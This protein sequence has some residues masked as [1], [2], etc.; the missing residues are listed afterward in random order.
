MRGCSCRGTSGLCTCRAWRSR[1][2]FC[3]RRPRE[4]FGR[5]G[6]S[7]KVVTV[8]T[9]AACASKIPRHRFVRAQLGVLEDR[10]GA[11]GD[12][13]GLRRAAMTRAWERFGRCVCARD[14]LSVREASW[15]WSG[16]V[17]P[18]NYDASA[19]RAIL[20]TRIKLLDGPK[21]PQS[22]TVKYTPD[23]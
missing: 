22:S 1:R 10:T 18:K 6:V 7:G 14:A 16:A 12:G 17:A 3:S 15:L 4:P 23:V 19:C 8:V 11:A 13:H 21:R 20:R 2:R 5:Q 9:R